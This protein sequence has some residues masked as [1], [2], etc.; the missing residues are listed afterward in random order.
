[1]SLDPDRCICHEHRPICH[2]RTPPP[3]RQPLG[4]EPQ[5]I[6]AAALFVAL[7]AFTVAP[8]VHR[9]TAVF[10]FFDIMGRGMQ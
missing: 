8:I 2:C 7:L 9:A 4:I 6:V 10:A 3:P 1:M 5:E